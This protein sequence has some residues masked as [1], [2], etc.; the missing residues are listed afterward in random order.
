MTE[1]L[2]DFGTYEAYGRTTPGVGEWKLFDTRVSEAQKSSYENA[3]KVTD[4]IT[5]ATLKEL[6]FEPARAKVW[7]F[8]ITKE[9]KQ[10]AFGKGLLADLQD[11]LKTDA[12]TLASGLGGI[13]DVKIESLRRMREIANRRGQTLRQALRGMGFNKTN[14]E[15]LVKRLETKIPGEAEVVKPE[16]GEVYLARTGKK[17]GKE[18]RYP[19]IFQHLVDATKNA[20]EIRKRAITNVFDTPIRTFE[21]A[22]PEIKQLIYDP[23]RAAERANIVEWRGQVKVLGEITK[24]FSNRELERIGRYAI[25]Q[26]RKGQEILGAMGKDFPTEL[27]PREQVLYTELR[28]HYKAL[29]DRINVMRRSN[30]MKA[31]QE[32]DNYFTFFSVFNMKERMGMKFNPVLDKAKII[33]QAYAQASSTPFRFAKHR[34]KKLMPIETNAL[35]MYMNYAEPA[36][37]HIHITPTVALI[38]ELR[39]K[40]KVDW[41][42]KGKKTLLKSAKPRLDNFLRVW[43]NQ[44]TGIDPLAKRWPKAS[45][46]AGILSRNL[47]FSILGA[48]VRSALIQTTALRNTATEIGFTRT[49]EGMARVLNP[50]DWSMAHKLSEVLDARVMSAATADALRFVRGKKFGKVRQLTGSAALWPL[51]VLDHITATATWLGAYKQGRGWKWGEK[52]ASVYA[53]DVVT[54]TQASALPGDLSRMQTNAL[55]KAVSLFQTFVINDFQFLAKD[56]LGINNPRLGNKAITAKVIRYV[57]ATTLLNALLEDVVG[58]SSPFPTPIRTFRRKREEGA[59]NIETL[60]SLAME[61]LE[62]IPI[63]GGFRYGSTPLGAVAQTLGEV[64]PS[65]TGAPLAKHPLEP[66]LKLA[67]VPGTAQVTKMQRARARGQEGLEVVLGTF[68]PRKSGGKRR[69]RSGRTRSRR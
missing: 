29:F 62:P 34:T 24:G 69:G 19:V 52:R 26:Q 41:T 5:N 15:E 45:K 1:E 63:V 40:A 46:V 43:A 54:K 66:I 38:K 51:K 13:G 65:L 58:V 10:S 67:G 48:N 39:Q 27:T 53:D 57:A 47:T 8:P 56:V 35:N 25:G 37:R 30:G 49:T 59:E 28:G 6:K 2:T 42:G 17:G 31:I 16:G 18:V 22:G 3:Y 21:E 11:I 68:K 55:G 44:I 12:N 50:K 7:S 14:A 9:M 33:D 23:Y 64:P 36:I 32:V 60:T 61:M 20:N 4:P